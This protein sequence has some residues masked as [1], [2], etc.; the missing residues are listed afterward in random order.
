MEN[1]FHNKLMSSIIAENTYILIFAILMGVALCLLFLFARLMK[2][3]HASG[4][5]TVYPMLLRVIYEV[6]VTGI[7]IFP[8]LG[9][10]GTVKALLS[11]D[12]T[13]DLAGAQFKFFDALTSTAWGIIFAVIFK[14]LNAFVQP[15]MERL[16]S[17]RPPQS[18]EAR[19]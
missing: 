14:L 10:Y 17:A 19:K 8:L 3:E 11:L 7:T 4:R 15:F 13:N 5:R 12:F 9:M 6:F 16:L 2:R 18:K 1:T